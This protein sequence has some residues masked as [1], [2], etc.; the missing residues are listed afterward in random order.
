MWKICQEVSQ[1]SKVM[2]PDLSGLTRQNT[3]TN[4]AAFQAQ[5]GILN[6]E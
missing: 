6:L 2:T 4:L 3:Q 1:K 5:F